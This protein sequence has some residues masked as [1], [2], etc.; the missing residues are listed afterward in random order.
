MATGKFDLELPCKM[1]VVENYNIVL[2]NTQTWG[3]NPSTISGGV[4]TKNNIL[5]VF[6]TVMGYA[7]TSYCLNSDKSLVY[8]NFPAVQSV[9]LPGNFIFFYK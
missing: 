1:L 5:G 4:V 6:V 8:V 2:N 9:T 3:E 7:P